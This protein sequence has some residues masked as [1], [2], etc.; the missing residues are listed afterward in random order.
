VIA[1]SMEANT[2]NND[3]YAFEGAAVSANKVYMPSAFCNFGS[4]KQN[5]A[6]AVQNVSTSATASVTVNYSSGN[7]DGPFDILPGQKKSFPGCGT[8]GTVNPAGFIGSATI[9]SEGAEIVAIAKIGGGGLS[10]AFLG[11]TAGASKVA[12]PYV[13]WTESQ[14]YSGQRQRVNIAIQ[15]VGTADLAIGDVQIKYIDKDGNQVG[16]TVTNTVVLKPGDKFSTNAKDAGSAAY[17]FGYSGTSIGGGAIVQ[18][19]TNS[20]LAVI[21]RVSTYQASGAVG[22]DYSAFPIQ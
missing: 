16:N 7:S 5:S 9:V 13:R 1:T 4:G 10:T 22:E 21:A 6:Y 8:T 19:P 3:V 18:G 12:L 11:F 2:S 15:N 14:W 17:E 20:A